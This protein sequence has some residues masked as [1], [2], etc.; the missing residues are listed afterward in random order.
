MDSR[1]ML[2]VRG[3]AGPTAVRYGQAPDALSPAVPLPGCR[4]SGKLFT[5]S[6]CLTVLCDQT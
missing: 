3:H 1:Q 6:L 5:L 2:L 4:S